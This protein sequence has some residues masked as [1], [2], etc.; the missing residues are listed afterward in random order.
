MFNGIG[1]HIIVTKPNRCENNLNNIL[2][3]LQHVYKQLQDDNINYLF[4]K[5][6]VSIW[7][8]VPLNESPK[9]EQN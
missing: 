6:R 7:T 4:L 3:R 8:S 1:L 2:Y 9:F 5:N